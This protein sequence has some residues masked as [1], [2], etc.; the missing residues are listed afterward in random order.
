MINEQ[1]KAVWKDLDQ[2]NWDL[3]QGTDLHCLEG[4]AKTVKI[5]SGYAV[6]AL[7]HEPGTSRIWNWSAITRQLHMVQGTRIHI[8]FLHP[9]Y[10]KTNLKQFWIVSFTTQHISQW[11]TIVLLES[12]NFS[13][14]YL[15]LHC[16]GRVSSCNI[17]AV[18]QDTQSFLM[19]EFIYHLC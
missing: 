2:R 10:I 18:Q 5:L 8:I 19:S 11:Y 6:S 1:W 12:V 14:L 4:L 13:E 15:V 3:S 17:Y 16:R 7:R 9:P